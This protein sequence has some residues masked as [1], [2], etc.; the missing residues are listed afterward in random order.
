MNDSSSEKKFCTKCF[1]VNIIGLGV[2]AALL[3]WFFIF[4]V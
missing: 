3:L 4:K 1:V 2:I